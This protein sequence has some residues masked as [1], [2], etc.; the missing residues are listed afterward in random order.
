LG[1]Y[2]GA[3]MDALFGCG[4][5]SEWWPHGG[6]VLTSEMQYLND[7]N[8]LVA[9]AVSPQLRFFAAGVNAAGRSDQQDRASTGGAG[10][11]P[12]DVLAE[13][14][15]RRG[16]DAL[17][18]EDVQQ[19]QPLPDMPMGALRMSDIIRWYGGAY[20]PPLSSTRLGSAS[21]LVGA[22]HYTSK[23]AESGGGPGPYDNGPLRGAWLSQL[24]VNWMGD[25]GDLKELQYSLRL[26]NLVGD[27][28]TVKGRV[29]RIAAQVARARRPCPAVL[30]AW[31]YS[32]DICRCRFARV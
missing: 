31:G 1:E 11:P 10:I 21:D 27:V 30:V 13:R 24:V 6:I 12:S 26:F 15:H 29:E 17:Y 8:E 3:K 2:A 7:G 22:G 16:P 23:S 25:S 5:A 19:G 18:S 20:G 4:M 28:N 32:D 9:R 14:R